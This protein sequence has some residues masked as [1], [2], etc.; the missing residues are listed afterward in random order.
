[1][2]ALAVAIII[3]GAATTFGLWIVVEFMQQGN[4]VRA[5]VAPFWVIVPGCAPLAILIVKRRRAARSNGTR[6]NGNQR[7][8]GPQPRTR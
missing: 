4:Y 6:F 1:M 3:A 8:K 2:V 7:H 5:A